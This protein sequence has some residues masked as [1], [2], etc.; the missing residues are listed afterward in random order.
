M[1]LNKGCK[2]QLNAA[3]LAQAQGFAEK[4]RAKLQAGEQAFQGS[5]L[6]KSLREKTDLN[7]AR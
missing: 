6:L 5:D 1:R 2:V 7:K 3:G 4:S